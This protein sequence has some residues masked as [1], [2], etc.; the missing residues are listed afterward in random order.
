MGMCTVC[1]GTGA[2]LTL[3]ILAHIEKG[4]LRAGFAPIQ[5][6]PRSQFLII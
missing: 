4:H 1:V 3:P 2:S 5:K 6:F